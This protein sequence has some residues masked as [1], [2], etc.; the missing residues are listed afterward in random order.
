MNNQAVSKDAKKRAILYCRSL[1]NDSVQPQRQSD[2]LH[3]YAK[4]Q[5]FCVT[6]T[7]ITSGTID[8][9]TYHS[10]RLRARYREFEVLLIT[11]LD[12]LGNSAIEI[13]HE[14]NFLN[15][16]GVKIISLKDG[17]LNSETLPQIFRK[18]FKLVNCRC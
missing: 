17:E 8:P 10:F 5:G 18:N 3:V 7:F 12:V 14:I 15:E 1:E 6:E 9:L 16:N 4:E 2:E 11:E 13:T